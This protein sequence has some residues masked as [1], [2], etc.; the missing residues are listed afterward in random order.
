MANPIFH[1]HQVEGHFL[2]TCPSQW[3]VKYTPISSPQSLSLKVCVCVYVCV[4]TLLCAHVCVPDVHL[5]YCFSG[6]SQFLWQGF[7]FCSELTEEVRLVSPKD[8]QIF[9]LVLV[10]RSQVHMLARQALHWMSHHPPLPAPFP[11]F[12]IALWPPNKWS[13]LHLL[14]SALGRAHEQGLY[15]VRWCWFRIASNTN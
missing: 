15:F 4:C 2:V 3:S 13:E 6:V 5:G 7:L 9:T 10:G 8:N 11:V 12:P 14:P 1:P